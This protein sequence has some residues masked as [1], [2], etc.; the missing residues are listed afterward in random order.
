MVVIQKNSTY[1]SELAEPIN[2]TTQ[3]RVERT[4]TVSTDAS[5]EKSG[6]ER[7]EKTS[8]VDTAYSASSFDPSEENL[9]YLGCYWIVVY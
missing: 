9:V 5:S 4:T 8:D 3:I 1:T 7:S 6:K 2:T